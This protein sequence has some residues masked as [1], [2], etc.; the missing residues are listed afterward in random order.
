[1]AGNTIVQDAQA[2]IRFEGLFGSGLNQIPLGAV[3][4]SA[5]LE[6]QTGN[7]TWDGTSDITVTGIHRLLRP[8]DVAEPLR[9]VE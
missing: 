1:M 8:F 5:F 6:L 7:I 2:L 4:D 9:S 3:I